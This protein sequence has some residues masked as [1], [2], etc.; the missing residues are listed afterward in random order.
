MSRL[1][2]G[3]LCDVEVL[4][5]CTIIVVAACVGSCRMSGLARS[6]MMIIITRLLFFPSHNSLLLVFP[7]QRPPLLPISVSGS[8]LTV[9]LFAVDRE[10]GPMVPRGPECVMVAFDRKQDSARLREPRPTHT[11]TDRDLSRVGTPIS[12]P[13][14]RG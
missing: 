8:F 12:R 2:R 13:R 3:A 14:D 4:S 6:S 1:A 11:E 10:S 9:A 5:S 7:F